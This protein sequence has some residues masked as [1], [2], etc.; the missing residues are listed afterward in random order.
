M[1]AEEAVALGLRGG[2]V[3]VPSAAVLVTAAEDPATDAA[4]VGSDLAITDSG[5]MILF[6]LARKWECIPRYVKAIKLI[7][8]M[9]RWRASL[10]GSTSR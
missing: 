3:V 5:L 9:L 6:W 10:P 2:L 7:F 1:S 8:L 4:L